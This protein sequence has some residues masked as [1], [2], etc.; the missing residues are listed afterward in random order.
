MVKKVGDYEVH[1][2]IGSGTYSRIHTGVFNA[3]SAKIAIKMLD[4][5]KM[6]KENVEE[7]FREEYQRVR[8]L[9]HPTVIYVQQIMFTKHHM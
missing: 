9:S 4:R 8:S 7:Q 6:I 5:R 2:S 3:T 1:K